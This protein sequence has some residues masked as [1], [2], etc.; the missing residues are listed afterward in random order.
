MIPMINARQLSHFFHKA[1]R[2]IFDDMILRGYRWK[3]PDSLIIE[4]TNRCTLR[5]TCCPNGNTTENRARGMM[6]RDTFESVLANLDVPIKTCF[7][8]MCGEPFLNPNLDYFCRRLLER[9]IRPVIFS[10]GYGIDTGMLGRILDLKGVKISFSMEVNSAE[11]YNEIRVPGRHDLAVEYLGE[12]DRMFREHKRIF[13]L[14]IILRRGATAGS[15]AADCRRLFAG[16]QALQTITFS[17]LWPWP[18]LPSTGDLAGHLSQARPICSHAKHLPTVLWDGRTTFCAL[19]FAGRMITGD[20]TRCKMSEI[21]NN[22]ASRRFRRMIM[23]SRD[24][25]GTLCH[26][27][28]NNRVDGYNLTITRG[29]FLKAAKNGSEETLLQGMDEYLNNPILSS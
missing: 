28:I 15:V 19:D 11:T 24:T 14:N 27:C 1:K 17:S 5:C 2:R 7:L 6:T 10:N 20:A 4:T 25:T 23:G 26:K 18:G 8:H 12:I 9:K 21:V 16:Y 22:K 3:F 29:L 13:G